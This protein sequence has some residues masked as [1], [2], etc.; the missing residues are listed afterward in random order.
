MLN[1]NIFDKN[2]LIVINKY[3]KKNLINYK[4]FIYIFNIILLI[5]FEIDIILKY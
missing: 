5:S 4:N 3:N 2:N 1:L